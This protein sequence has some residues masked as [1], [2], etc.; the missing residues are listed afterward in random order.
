[1]DT[2]I[3]TESGQEYGPPG[4]M[5]SRGIMDGSFHLEYEYDC[6]CGVDGALGG[7]IMDTVELRFVEGNINKLDTG[8][9]N[10][11]HENKDD[12]S[13]FIVKVCYEN[14]PYSAEFVL[15]RKNLYVIGVQKVKE[16]NKTEIIEFGS[17]SY[18]D[19]Y[20]IGINMNRDSIKTM[21]K[22]FQNYKK[23]P[24]KDFDKNLCIAAFI[25]SE[26]ARFDFIRAAVKRVCGDESDTVRNAFVNWVN[27]EN[28]YNQLYYYLQLLHSY[29]KIREQRS[30]HT[31]N[32]SVDNSREYFYDDAKQGST[33]R[34]NYN[35]LIWIG[36]LEEKKVDENYGIGKKIKK[37]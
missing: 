14:F 34:E 12:E 33:A 36:L 31:K 9:T 15:N 27:T 3:Y 24:N 18:I 26:A 13:S 8:W 25:I 19:K 17:T 22:F 28:I 5:V 20:K 21:I 1:M 37:D 32:I 10:I 35:G 11:I 7:K 23:G 30:K 2:E 4:N 6:S 16:N 29:S